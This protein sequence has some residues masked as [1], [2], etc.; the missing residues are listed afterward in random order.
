[1]WILSQTQ[2]KKA[3]IQ[4]NRNIEDTKT[5]PNKEDD[6]KDKLRG[7][8]KSG[9]N[10]TAIKARDGDM[11]WHS[12]RRRKKNWTCLHSQYKEKH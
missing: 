5:F 2:E 11:G 4:R 7:K 9:K 3:A 6:C 12:E 8:E 10:I 1:M